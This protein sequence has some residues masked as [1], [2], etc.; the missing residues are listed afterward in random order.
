MAESDLIYG[1]HDLEEYRD[2][3]L[4]E[5][6]IVEI[7][8]RIEQFQAAQNAALN[9]MTAV[10]AQSNQRWNE[11]PINKYTM[12]VTMDMQPVDEDGVAKPVRGGASYQIG[13]PLY[14]REFAIGQT[15]EASK[16]ATVAQLN[17]D[18]RNL[19]NADIYS[20]TMMMFRALFPAT[21]FT[22]YS[23]EEN[24][25]EEIPVLPLA[26]GDSQ[27]YPLP[28][29]Q[30]QTADHYTAQAAGVADASDPFPTIYSRLAAYTPAGVARPRIVS[31]FNG[32]T[33]AAEIRALA[34]FV[35]VSNARYIQPGM[36]DVELS[37]AIF[38]DI[39]FGDEVLGEHTSGVTVVR[40][41]TLPVDYIFSV[42]LDRRP[43]GRRE[44]P[45]AALR[46]LFSTSSAD[47]YGN[48][49]LTRFR[50]K[51]GF[52]VVD[53][54]GAEILR[55]RNGTYATPTGYEVLV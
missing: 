54:L 38:N 55:V 18:L 4:A 25:P 16:V 43:L 41:R 47:R 32:D 53:R 5:I 51:Q 11:S 40:W 45:S 9:L 14:R 42:N 31:F 7:N 15:W 37:D 17:E 50:R 34:D 29:G 46:G 33:L 2:Y 23:T 20:T 30:T 3:T 27:T 10:F 49:L 1:L 52:G 36:G 48:E 39:F 13:L 19:R 21:G 6:G 8:E 35:P 28:N 26:N 24:M 12:P 22:F 44:D